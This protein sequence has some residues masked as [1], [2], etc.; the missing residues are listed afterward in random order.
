MFFIDA[1]Y[2]PTIGS[3]RPDQ[4]VVKFVS[5][6]VFCFFAVLLFP[7]RLQSS[8][9]LF[10]VSAKNLLTYSHSTKKYLWEEKGKERK[11]KQN[12]SFVDPLHFIQDSPASSY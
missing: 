8:S 4:F 7:E 6:F 11:T 5:F 10:E 2:C 1:P 9:L 12:N 3:L